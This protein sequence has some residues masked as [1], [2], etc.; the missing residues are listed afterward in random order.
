MKITPFKNEYGNEIIN[1]PFCSYW[2]Y[3]RKSTK[4]SPNPLRDLLRHIHNESKK[5]ALE[6]IL[7]NNIYFPHLDYFREHTTIAPEMK[8][9]IKRNFDNDLVLTD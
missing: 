7:N 3:T 6:I 5:E 1:C 8:K 2:C 4:I 9:Y